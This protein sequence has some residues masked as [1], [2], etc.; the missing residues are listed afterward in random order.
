MIL[1]PLFASYNMYIDADLRTY[2]DTLVAKEY[3]FD[4]CMLKL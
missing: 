4:R 1:V 2:V 3:K